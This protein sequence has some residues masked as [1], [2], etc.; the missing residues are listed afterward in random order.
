MSE[1]LN[2]KLEESVFGTNKYYLEII[3]E[4]VNNLSKEDTRIVIEQDNVYLKVKDLSGV[5]IINFNLDNNCL[6][7]KIEKSIDFRKY[8]EVIIY[9]EYGVMLERI[10]SKAELKQDI[11]DKFQDNQE[12]I[13]A[14][15]NNLGQNQSIYTGSIFESVDIKKVKRPSNFSL[16]GIY[17][18]RSMKYDNMGQMNGHELEGTFKVFKSGS[19][20][21]LEIPDEHDVIVTKEQLL[22]DDKEYTYREPIGF[23]R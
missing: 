13:T 23:K 15:L 1:E 8:Q 9:D 19:I 21:T 11:N 17:S 7:I 4:F 10:R 22:V 6:R 18:H 14:E 2:K 3:K 20:F 16:D 12:I 5:K